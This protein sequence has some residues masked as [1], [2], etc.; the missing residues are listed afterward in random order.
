MHSYRS[1]AGSQPSA[2]GLGESLGVNA[3]FSLRHVLKLADDRQEMADINR[4]WEH[5]GGR[6]GPL[7]FP[8]SGIEPQGG[9][10]EQFFQGGD[11]KIQDNG[12]LSVTK[13]VEYTIRFKGLH[14]F[15]EQS[16]PWLR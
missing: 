12:Q 15:G 16:R 10:F 2:R 9:G 6:L 8:V 11:I 3:P 5:N 1:I 14:C 7:G 13:R 4:A